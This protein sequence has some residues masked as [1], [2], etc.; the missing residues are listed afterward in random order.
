MRYIKRGI[1]S[2]FLTSLLGRKA[3][4]NLDTILKN[5]DITLLTKGHIVELGIFQKSCMDVKVEP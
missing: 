1:G 3:V 4:T 5:R 2:I